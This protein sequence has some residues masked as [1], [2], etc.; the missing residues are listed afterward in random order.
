M[1][2]LISLQSAFKTVKTY[3]VTCV[4]ITKDGIGIHSLGSKLNIVSSYLSYDCVVYYVAI[5][6]HSEL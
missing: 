6:S 5:S 2:G 1:L 4:Q 3:Y